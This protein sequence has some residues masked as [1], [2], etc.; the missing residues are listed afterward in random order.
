MKVTTNGEFSQITGKGKT[1][2]KAR[3]AFNRSLQEALTDATRSMHMLVCG[4]GQTVLLVRSQ[5]GLWAYS[6]CHPDH[7]GTCMNFETMEE[8]VE[9]A[10][11]HAN[12]CF[13]GVAWRTRVPAWRYW[14][15]E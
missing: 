15:Q 12:Q 7:E 3:Q 13:G 8:A 9:A 14:A 1:L 11:E 10:E 5:G 4:D 2:A 6:V